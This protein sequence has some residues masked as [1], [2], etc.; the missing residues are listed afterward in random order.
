MI[1]AEAPTKGLST[2]NSMAFGLAVY[3]SQC[4]LPT[5]H[6]R[7]TSGCLASFAGRA[8]L[9]AGF[10]R[11]VSRHS[12]SLPRLRLAQTDWSSSDGNLRQMANRTRTAAFSRC[13]VVWPV[14]RRGE[15]LL[16][17]QAGPARRASLCVEPIGSAW[18][19]DRGRVQRAM[20]RMP[21][22]RNILGPQRGMADSR[23]QFLQL[24]QSLAAA[25]LVPSLPPDGAEPSHGRSSGIS[26]T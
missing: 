3:A 5:P 8:W 4:G 6:A 1:K 21:E 14:F 10:L 2:L 20:R 11:K 22:R 26:S 12:S 23:G 13:D 9:P 25:R 19:A 15:C 18:G 17:R 7:L 16:A 24:R